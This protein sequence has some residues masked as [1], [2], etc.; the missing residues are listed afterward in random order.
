MNDSSNE[1]MSFAAAATAD[2]VIASKTGIFTRDNETLEA[3]R[4]GTLNPSSSIRSPPSSSSSS[5]HAAMAVPLA[6]SSYNTSPETLSS[7]SNLAVV[8]LLD[9]YSNLQSDREAVLQQIQAAQWHLEE[10]KA[11]MQDSLGAGR[12]W[13]Q[14]T[15]H[16]EQGQVQLE[17]QLQAITRDQATAQVAHDQATQAL[18]LSKLQE[19]H[20]R[21]TVVKA[22]TDFIDSVQDLE[23]QCHQL[24][25]DHSSKQKEAVS[26]D[27]LP[28][29]QE[30]DGKE[31]D[32]SNENQEHD[33]KHKTKKL[34][35]ALQSVI[36]LCEQYDDDQE[37]E[38]L[39]A[40]TY[41][42]Q[43][44]PPPP[45]PDDTEL[46][47][48]INNNRKI[49]TETDGQDPHLMELKDRY[50]PLLAFALVEERHSY[51]KKAKELVAVAKETLPESN[52]E[53]QE[54]NTSASQP[55]MSDDVEKEQ[56]QP[57]SNTDDKKTDDKDSCGT[58]SDWIAIL[59]ARLQEDSQEEV[60]FDKI[61]AQ[62][63]EQ[64]ASAQ[65][66]HDA[67]QASTL[68][69]TKE[70]DQGMEK[71]TQQRAQ[72]KQLESQLDRMLRDVDSLEDQVNQV[73]SDIAQ[74]DAP[75]D[76]D[77]SGEGEDDEDSHGTFVLFRKSQSREG[78]HY[79]E[80]D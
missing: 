58:P 78:A 42:F 6:S 56:I 51:S 30:G 72:I 22:R 12:D 34:P 37:D 7:S 68:D 70:H 27:E 20:T 9:K 77:Y 26:K 62:L 54:P 76:S 5:G 80:T 44:K 71:R 14:Q 67:E 3:T 46:S 28:S 74:F 43:K 55:C 23:Q 16:A 66:G 75:N 19:Q 59:R 64:I 38:D 65:E 31:Q 47:S 69:I 45:N 32:A 53:N 36:D 63:E 29:S 21:E 1:A 33:P 40:L 18:K 39:Q 4:S 79:S 13:Q 52:R 8:S 10:T 15:L 17:A 41:A 57:S 49:E 11:K 2:A 48:T 35:E 25:K 50:I 24:W 60:A 61:V 73:Q